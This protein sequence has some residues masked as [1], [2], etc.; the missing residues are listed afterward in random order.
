MTSFTASLE[1]VLPR[2][3]SKVADAGHAA[4]FRNGVVV[5]ETVIPSSLRFQRNKMHNSPLLPELSPTFS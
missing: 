4:V 2:K 1:R 5:F 3:E